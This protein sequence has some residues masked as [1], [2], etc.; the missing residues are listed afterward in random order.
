MSQKS[1][2]WVSRNLVARLQRGMTLAHVTTKQYHSALSILPAILATVRQDFRKPWWENMLAILA[3]VI[4]LF[5]QFYFG[6]IKKGETISSALI[7]ISPYLLI[8]IP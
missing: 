7:K 5:F 2:L 8:L 1:D 4:A 6:L 3:V